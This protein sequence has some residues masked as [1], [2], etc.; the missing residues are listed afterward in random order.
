[1]EVDMPWHD[2]R[3]WGLV[4]GIAAGA[5]PARASRPSQCRLRSLTRAIHSN[6]THSGERMR[7]ASL[8]ARGAAK[9]ERGS[10]VTGIAAGAPG[11]ATQQHESLQEKITHSSHPL[12]PDTQWRAHDAH[13]PPDK[14]GC[15]QGDGERSD[16]HS[17]GGARLRDPAARVTAGEDHA[18]EPSTQTRHSVACERGLR[19]SRQDGLQRGR[20]GAE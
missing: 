11:C 6:Q 12:K 7:L 20:G 16:W 17:G 19:A 4:T 15:K 10:G 9:R 8:Q 2:Q 5:P 18:L 1:M 14:K 13:E 3:A